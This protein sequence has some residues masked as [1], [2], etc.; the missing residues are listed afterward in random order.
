MSLAV[1]PQHGR[2]HELDLALQQLRGQ[3]PT[4]MREQGQHSRALAAVGLLAEQHCSP[5]HCRCCERAAC[6]RMHS[7]VT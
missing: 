2:E 1:R 7:R 5:Y 3:A 6:V 4:V